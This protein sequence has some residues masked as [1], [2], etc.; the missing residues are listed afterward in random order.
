MCE[1]GMVRAKWW[2][3]SAGVGHVLQEQCGT[4]LPATG[5]CCR[6]MLKISRGVSSG[7]G[8]I[9]HIE[10][11]PAHCSLCFEFR[12]AEGKQ[13]ALRRAQMA[14]PDGLC[15][16]DR[17][18]VFCPTSQTIA[19]RKKTLCLQPHRYCAWGCFSL[20]GWACG[21]TRRRR[22]RRTSRDRDRSRSPASRETRSA[23]RS[24][25]GKS[26][27]AGRR[28]RVRCAR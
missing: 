6:K 7:A 2:P 22:S 4:L 19:L 24:G 16:D 14:R 18:P 11:M 25:P 20:F 1:R 15:D 28:A 23:C 10:R 17:V 12:L 9:P 27:N 5:L 13:L 21:F 26:R 8:I 3:R